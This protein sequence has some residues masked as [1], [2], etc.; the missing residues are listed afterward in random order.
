MREYARRSRV[1]VFVETGTFHGDTIHALMGDFEE[2]ISV[3]L[4]ERLYRKAQRRFSG[5]RKVALFHG[6]SGEVLARI[7]PGITRPALF[8]L[9][10]H[11]SSGVTARGSIDTPL[12]KEVD[13]ILSHPLARQHVILIDDARLLRGEDGYPTFEALRE[14]VLSAGLGTCEIRNDIVRILA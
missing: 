9:D 8:W 6:D 5:C 12:Y 1:P 2:L 11:Y 14:R 7:L 10:A 3:E 4:S 13:L